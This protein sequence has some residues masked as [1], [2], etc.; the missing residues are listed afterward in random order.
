M[1]KEEVL[2]TLDR[3]IADYGALNEPKY[4]HADI[5]LLKRDYGLLMEMKEFLKE[6]RSHAHIVNAISQTIRKI[7]APKGNDKITVTERGINKA[8]PPVIRKKNQPVNFPFKWIDK[9]GNS[10]SIDVEHWGVWNYM[11]MDILGYYLLLKEGNNTVP[12]DPLPIFT[13]MNSIALREA[14]GISKNN[15]SLNLSPMNE[16][17]IERIEQT[18]YWVQFDDKD[19]RKSTSLDMSSNEIMNLLHATSRAEFKLVFPVRMRDEKGLKEINYNMNYFSRL[20]EFG[21]V[22]KEKRI[23]GVVINRHYRVSFNTLMGELFAHNLLSKSYDWLDNRFYHLPYNAQVFYRRLLVNNDL[24][25]ISINAKTIAERLN[26]QDKNITN[27]AG[28]IETNI[29]KPL[30]EQGLIDSYE[31]TKGG[32]FGLKYTI[33]RKKRGKPDDNKQQK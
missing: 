28:T 5:D 6:D 16:Q 15:T 26:L 10:C 12:K 30:I 3:I 29:L 13:D 9:K 23:D 33:M 7:T 20:F 1:T 22:D 17:D 4:K 8:I 27:L 19:F 18:R 21:Y 31:K 25:V 11:V 32:L 14:S 24:E 2:P